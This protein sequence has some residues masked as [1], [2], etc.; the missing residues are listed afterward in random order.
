[1]KLTAVAASPV[2]VPARR[3]G[4]DPAEADGGLVDGGVRHR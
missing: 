2:S 4:N 1:M 3:N